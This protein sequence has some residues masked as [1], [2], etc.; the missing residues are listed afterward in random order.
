V[1]V[2]KFSM[3]FETGTGNWSIVLPADID[4]WDFKALNIVIHGVK[5]YLAP[6]LDK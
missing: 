6:T 1:E 3:E 5:E 2:A 4:E